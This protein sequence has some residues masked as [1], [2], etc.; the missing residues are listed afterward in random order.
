[1]DLPGDRRLGIIDVPGHDRFVKNLVAG[2]SGI[3]FVTLVI[4]ADEGIM[5]Q[6]REHLEICTLLGIKTGLVAL[7]KID[8]VDEEW[9]EM[10]KEDVAGYLST[11]F[12]AGAPNFPVSAHTGQ[13]LD[14]LKS[15]L[16]DLVDTYQPRR[17]SDLARLPID[18]VFT[19]KGYG[20]VSRAR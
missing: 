18:R 14:A 7:T 13:G 15:A 11:T 2:A 6:T 10:V 1:M 5:P 17:R 3:D 4:A 12:L 20:T 16:S 8:M 9:L 19:L